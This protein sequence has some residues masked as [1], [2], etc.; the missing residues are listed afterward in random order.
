[1][2]LRLLFTMIAGLALLCG[3]PAPAQETLATYT[4]ARKFTAPKVEKMLFSYT[5]T[6]NYFKSGTRFWY[7]Y[8]TTDGTSWYVVDPAAA[9]KTPLF[10]RDDLAAKLT[11]YTKDPFEAQ[12]IALHGLKL[13]DDDSTFTFNVVTSQKDTLYF[14]YDLNSRQIS[15]RDEKPTREL[16]WA[17]IS[18]DKKYVVY[19]KD[20]NLYRMDYA[21]YRLLV[22]N[23]SDSIYASETQL[24]TDGIEDFAFGMP[25]NRLN[26]DTLLNHKRTSVYVVWSPDGKYFV[27]SL[28][29]NRKIK[30][31][32]VINSIAKPRPTLET[33]KY[34]MP[35]E[36]E[37]YVSHLYLFDVN[38]KTR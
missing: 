6:P 3:T 9:R 24:T 32:W 18:P 38:A 25:R 26:T 15:K 20:L 4:Q 2:N 7:E 17:N 36:E 10:D 1:M 5:V 33:Y 12:H 31:L 8:K 21:D 13:E 22:K 27:S 29:D 37:S 16:P 28:R 30:D 19:A 35:G 11:E 34:L 14:N 23:P